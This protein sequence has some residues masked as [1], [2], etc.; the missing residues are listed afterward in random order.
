MDRRITGYVEGWMGGWKMD[1]WMDAWMIGW[2]HACMHRC[3]DA[4]GMEYKRDRWVDEIFY[5]R[6][7]AL[8]GMN[9][10]RKYRWTNGFTDE[11]TLMEK[12]NERRWWVDGKMDERVD[13]GMPSWNGNH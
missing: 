9:E 11:S 12:G 4:W 10:G 2:M 6:K 7:G 3:M 5:G 13:V 8:K 1:G